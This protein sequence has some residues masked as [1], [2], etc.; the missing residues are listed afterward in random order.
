MHLLI[1]IVGRK[2]GIRNATLSSKGVRSASSSSLESLV[3]QLKRLEIVIDAAGINAALSDEVDAYGMFAGPPAELFGRVM[4]KLGPLLAP[5]YLV[6][7]TA[8]K[9][10]TT[11]TTTTTTVVVNP[12]DS[13]GNAAALA[14]RTTVSAPVLVRPAFGPAYAETT[15]TTRRRLADSALESVTVTVVRDSL[16]TRYVTVPV[17]R[18]HASWD[19]GAEPLKASTMV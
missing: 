19:G 3:D 1:D 16:R 4:D 17:V 10:T 13:D 9:R 6:R 7:T 15:I 11:T 2:H 12:D 8:T 18:L 14:P 5:A